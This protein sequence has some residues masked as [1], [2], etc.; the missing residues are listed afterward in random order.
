VENYMLLEDAED[1]LHDVKLQKGP[2]SK[3]SL[4]ALI[5]LSS[6]LSLAILSNLYLILNWSPSS[7]KDSLHDTTKY[8]NLIADQHFPF[9]GYSDYSSTNLTLADELW[10]AIDFDDGL[11]ALPN[12]WTSSKGL[13]ESARFPWDDSRSIWLIN[14]YHGLHC[15]K[16]IYVSLMEYRKNLPQSLP[17]RHIAHCLDSLRDQI[18]CDADDTPRFTRYR[19]DD[20]HLTGQEQTRQCRDWSKLESFA[21]QNN[22]CYRYGDPTWDKK[23]QYERF[24][25]CPT[26]SPYLPVVRE[27]FG[28]D[29]DWNPTEL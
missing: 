7:P 22:A 12:R 10:D 25:F 9:V 6:L 29:N 1:D 13:P 20:G 21:K 16:R 27:F 11:V 28:K 15:V 23:S 18:L 19:T 4:Y 17:T 5:I 8:A 3:V 14:G 26:D 2:P 24:M